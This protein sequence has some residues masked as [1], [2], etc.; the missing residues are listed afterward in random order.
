MLGNDAGDA[1]SIISA[2]TLAHIESMHKNNHMTPIISISKDAFTHERPDINLLLQLAGIE[3]PS[4]K[5]L[6][7]EDL[8]DILDS[9]AGHRQPINAITLVDHNTINMPLQKHEQDLTV[10]EI[11]DHHKDEGLYKDTCTGSRRNIAFDHDR[12]MVAST[13]TLVAEILRGYPPPYP[14]SLGILLLGVILLDSVNLD[15]SVGKV[16]QRDRDAVDDL[17]LH[18]DWSQAAPTSFITIGDDGG[19]EIDTNELFMKLQGAKYDPAFWS[20][21]STKRAL[22]YDYKAFHHNG[23]GLG[24]A[25]KEER[26]H[27]V[28]FGISSVLMSGLDFMQKDDFYNTTLD[29]MKSKQIPLLGIMFAFYDEWKVFYRQLA[30]VWVRQTISIHELLAS[31]MSSEDLQLEEVTL[32]KKLRRSEDVCLFDQKNVAPSRKQIGPM[33]EIF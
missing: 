28:N 11:V 17:T 15:E 7:I 13:T 6:F 21:V 31:L 16:T 10:A 3:D 2:I 12:A 27:E 33:L 24:Y 30:F 18:T 25:L 23:N 32:P 20:H 9:G 5:L 19:I 8:I 14:T 1:D 4:S 22:D 29:F 26:H